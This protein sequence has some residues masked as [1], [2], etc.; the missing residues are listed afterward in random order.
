MPSARA[1]GQGDLD[2]PIYA[3]WEITLRCNHA[4]AHCG[5]RA[6]PAPRETELSTAE[7]LDVAAE[8]IRLG[9]R[10]VT[11]IGGEAYLRPDIEELVRFLASGGV[12]VT[13]QTGG[14]GLSPRLARRLKDAGMKAVGVSVDGPE[15]IHDVLRD[16]A[17]SWR[18][19]LRA[20]E[21]CRE[22]GL[23]T[24]ANTQ[25]NNLT[26]D[27]L[28]ETGWMLRDQGV[29]VWRVQL[30]VPMGRAADRPEWILDPPRILDV[31]DT[32]AAMQLQAVQEA[33]DAGLPPSRAFA[34]QS[35]NNIGY[36]GPTEEILR[37]YPGQGSAYWTGCQA[38]R[39]TIGIESDGTVKGC[40]SLPTAPYTGGNL[41]EVPLADIWADAEAIRFVRDRDLAELWGFCKT[42]YYADVCR[43][44]CSFTSH[45]TLGRRGN[46]PFCYHRA[47]TLK[48]RGLRERLVQKEPAA[49]EP[50]DFGR[51]EVIEEPW[52]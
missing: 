10:E 42:C 26:W 47:A 21:V 45:C 15:A 20:L 24:T 16:S 30:T 28:E 46:N 9:T 14:R 17:G 8:L 35:S 39:Y 36:Y 4:C 48:K 41:R 11:L 33:R 32:L 29:R 44:G 27:K 50:Y 23:I 52:G 7:L 13:M 40:P 5:S 49:G 38:G 6:G 25:I 37:S 2:K 34:I 1:I 18:A 51:F 3:V 22:V 19:A 12:R 43:A 31:C